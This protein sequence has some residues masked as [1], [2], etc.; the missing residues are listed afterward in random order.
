MYE[1]TEALGHAEFDVVYVS[2]GAFASASCRVS[3]VGPPRLALWWLRADGF[4][5]D[6]TPIRGRSPMT[7]WRSSRGSDRVQAH[8]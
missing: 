5:F 3:I 1:A 2:L 6:G 7:A 8:V 4:N